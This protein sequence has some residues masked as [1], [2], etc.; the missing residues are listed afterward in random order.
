MAAKVLVV[1]DEPSMVK[2]LSTFMFQEGIP[3][4]GASSG[5]EALRILRAE[6]VGVIVT[7]LKMPGMDGLE[8]LER[9]LAVDPSLQIILTRAAAEEG[10]AVHRRDRR[11][12]G[13]VLPYK[14]GRSPRLR[15]TT[16]PATC[17]R[18]RTSWNGWRCSI[19]RG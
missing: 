16:V 9:A 6:D 14:R 12:C 5:E 13:F 1:D 7:D 17:A 19:S 8:L 11:S 15:P 10:R 3:C 18:C 2:V 4:A